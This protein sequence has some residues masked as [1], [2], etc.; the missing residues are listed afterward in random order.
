MLEARCD[1]NSKL[2]QTLHEEIAT[3]NIELQKAREAAEA[4]NST[5]SDFLANMSHELRTPMNS[6]I[7]FSEMI[8]DGIYGEVASEIREVVGEIQKSGEYLLGLINDV[9]DISKIEAGRMELRPSENAAEDCIETVI[10]RLA[11][12]AMEKGL[13]ISTE[14][15]EELPLCTFDPQRVTQV[16]SNL[17]GNAIKFTQKGEVRM[18]AKTKEE[19]LLFWVSDTGIGIPK[20]ELENIFDEFQQVDSSIEREVQGSG[21]GLS[22]AKKFVEMHGGE[23]WA[24]SEVGAGSTFW[25]TLPA[26]RKQ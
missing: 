18:G 26:K 19:D 13:A 16:L 1:R 6:V 12:L 15:H 23:I 17:A 25:F 10:G 9:L 5:K 8:L 3:T 7:G 11:S 2:F 14:I 22:I 21:L 24:E 4:A 20:G